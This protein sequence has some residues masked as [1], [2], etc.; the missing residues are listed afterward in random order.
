MAQMQVRRT[1]PPASQSMLRL[2]PVLSRNASAEATSLLIDFSSRLERGEFTPVD[3]VLTFFTAIFAFT[4]PS[5]FEVT[6]VGIG[7]L[8]LAKFEDITRAVCGDDEFCRLAL[9]YF[10]YA[11]GSWGEPI[12]A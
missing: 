7:E 6:R 10:Q 5:G 4:H 3:F 12:Y 2:L 8:M 1:F 9:E 11:K